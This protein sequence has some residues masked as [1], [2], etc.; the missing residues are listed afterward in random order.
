ML[1]CK[2]LGVFGLGEQRLGALAGRTLAEKVAKALGLRDRRLDHI[3]P[4]ERPNRPGARTRQ[5]Y[6][7]QRGDR[8]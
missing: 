6:C 7:E 3:G 5:G 1:P 4:G 2:R 8:G